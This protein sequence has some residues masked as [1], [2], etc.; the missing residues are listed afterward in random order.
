MVKVVFAQAMEPFTQGVKTTEVEANSYRIA[1]AKLRE[2]FPNL[3]QQVFEEYAVAIDD[4]I[5]QEPLLEA[6]KPNR[7]LVFIPKIV[8]G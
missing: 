3:S 6:L 7:E 8:A 1:L 2:K 4:V 5:I